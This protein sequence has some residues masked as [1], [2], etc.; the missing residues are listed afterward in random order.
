MLFVDRR[1]RVRPRREARLTVRKAAV[2]GLLAVVLGGCATAPTPIINGFPAEPGAHGSAVPL[3]DQGGAPPASP[4]TTRAAAAQTAAARHPG[5]YAA[6]SRQALATL[7]GEYYNGAGRWNMCVPLRCFT[8]NRDW[9]ADSLTYVLYLHWLLTRDRGV[10][11]IM[12][13]LA[14][15]SPRSH[16]GLS[17]VPLWDSIAAAREYQV[18]G[19][20]EALSKAEAYF[21]Y[22]AGNAPRLFALGACPGVLYQHAGGG[23]TQ[24]K[25][26]ESGAN[27]VKAAVLLYQI[28]HQRSYLAQAENQYQAVRQYFLSPGTSLYT[29][30]LFDNGNS[31]TQVPAQYYASVNGTMIWDGQAL[32]QI[33]GQSFY[34]NEATAAAQAVAAYLGDGTGVYADLQAENDIAEPLI[35]AM[36]GLAT[37]GQAFAR[38]W[39]LAAASASAASRNARTGAYGRFFDGPPQAGPVTAWQVNGGL[40]LAQVAAALDPTGRPARPGFWARASFVPDNLA[41]SGSPVSFS[42]TGRAVAIIGTIGEVCCTDGHAQVFIDGTQTFDQTGIWQNKS[43]S[44]RSLPDSVLFAWRWPRSGRH[45]IEIGPAAANAKQGG[46]FFHMTGYDVVR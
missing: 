36:Y 22:V 24:L 2:A 42:F 12:N 46:A 43:S 10:A 27:Y 13:A 26:L 28:T 40:A 21:G 23:G 44:D 25:T 45:T 39:L 8:S 16:S 41:L 35:E 14:T 15:T 18:T 19:N 29:V 17:D 4:P 33:T 11:P 37:S 31:C 1:V 3:A 20:R 34:L 30:Y 38:H 32:A 7:E 6:L 5:T 9:G